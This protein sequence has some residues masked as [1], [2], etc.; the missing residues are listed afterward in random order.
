MKDKGGTV[1]E[2]PNVGGGRLN[3]DPCRPSVF[4]RRPSSDGGQWRISHRAAGGLKGT[5]A[6]GAPG[7]GFNNDCPGEATR[8]VV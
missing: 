2:R 1:S 4:I 5:V 6:P 7:S 8:R 3:E